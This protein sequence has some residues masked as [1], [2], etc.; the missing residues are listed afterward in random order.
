MNYIIK[1]K[2][3]IIGEIIDNKYIPMPN[4]NECIFKFLK[5]EIEDVTKVNFFITRIKNCERF[6]N[7]S[8]SYSTDEYEFIKK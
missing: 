7:L 4:Q 3:N 1:Y 6:P 8:I 2:N 5:E